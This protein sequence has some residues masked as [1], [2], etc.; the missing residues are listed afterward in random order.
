MKKMAALIS[1][2]LVATGMLAGCGAKQEAAL[3]VPR[4]VT[5]HTARTTSRAN[6]HG[7]LPSKCTRLIKAPHCC[8]GCPQWAAKTCRDVKFRYDA[9]RAQ[10]VADDLWIESCKSVFF[11]ILYNN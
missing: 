2:A 6:A 8:N 10:V 5:R 7:L 9:K 1:N 3:I 11:T 4:S